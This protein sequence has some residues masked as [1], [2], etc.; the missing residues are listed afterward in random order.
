M[1]G[2]SCSF[3]AHERPC[4]CSVW[5]RWTSV[6]LRTDASDGRVDDI[7]QTECTISNQ[8][9]TSISSAPDLI[10]ELIAN[11][12]KVQNADYFMSVGKICGSLLNKSVSDSELSVF[13]PKIS[14][15]LVQNVILNVSA[16][17]DERCFSLLIYA[18]MTKAL[19]IK[20]LDVGF[21]MAKSILSLAED[22]VLFDYSSKAM[23]I[24]IS[25]DAKQVLT[26]ASFAC[27]SVLWLISSFI[28]KSFT[29][30]VYH[31]YQKHMK[32]PAKRGSI[33]T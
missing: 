29:T 2:S 11:A 17:P 16:H 12:R 5:W 21:Q 10:M 26:P 18:W 23:E 15:E 7:S 6:K 1:Q 33:C 19:V 4:E 32:R 30:F 13:L 22:N 3:D 8:T 14:Q 9:R 24:I 28:A 25:D 27:T 20:S 31:I